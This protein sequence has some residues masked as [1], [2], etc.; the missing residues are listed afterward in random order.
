MLRQGRTTNQHPTITSD[1]HLLRNSAHH[2]RVIL[3]HA[4]AVTGG[5]RFSR[6]H[7]YTVDRAG[8]PEFDAGGTGR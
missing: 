4:A 1:N 3:T 2:F 8:A 6:S 5:V 7:E